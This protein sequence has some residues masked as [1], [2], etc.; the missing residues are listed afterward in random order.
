MAGS[1]ATRMGKIVEML[2]NKV[3]ERMG[4]QW[5][6][7]SSGDVAIELVA[8]DR[9]RGNCKGGRVEEFLRFR[10]GELLLG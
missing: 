4:D 2:A 3:A 1:S 8:G 10:T 9:V 7:D 5:L 6:E